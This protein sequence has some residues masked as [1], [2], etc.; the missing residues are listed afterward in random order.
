[1]PDWIRSIF[2]SRTL[3]LLIAIAYLAIA[4]L[5]APSAAKAFAS[6]LIFGGALLLPLACI[7]FADEMGEYVGVLPGPAI[8]RK[9][10]AWMVKIGGWI[11]LLLPVIV[12]LF[13][14]RY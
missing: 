9:S 7:W 2:S 10:P 4:C 8:N 3:S 12:F 13:T 11:L 5:S 14:Y 1:M 6:L